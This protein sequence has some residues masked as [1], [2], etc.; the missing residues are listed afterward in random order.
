MSKQIFKVTV[1]YK[2]VND[3]DTRDHIIE[4]HNAAGVGSWARWAYGSALVQVLEYEVVENPLDVLDN[5]A[6]Q[7][8]METEV[9]GFGARK[10][11]EMFGTRVMLLTKDSVL[12]GFCLRGPQYKDN[13]GVYALDGECMGTSRYLEVWHDAIDF[14]TVT[15]H[16]GN[17][18]IITLNA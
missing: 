2:G 17:D 7:L 3:I 1:Q 13:W 4:A 18:Y 11:H 12:T 8:A 6:F 14:G 15:A 16:N 5:E 9:D 10:P